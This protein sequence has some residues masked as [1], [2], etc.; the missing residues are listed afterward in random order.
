VNARPDREGRHRRKQDGVAVGRGARGGLR[1]DDGA[2]TGAIFHDHRPLELLLQLLRQDA[3]E[4]VGA[5]AGGKRT[6]ESDRALRIVERLRGRSI[7]RG[8]AADQGE[9]DRPSCASMHPIGH[10]LTRTLTE[11]AVPISPARECAARY[12]G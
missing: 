8:K 5:A 11:Q 6:K 7:E 1:G 12:R 10:Y 9:N 4:D 2:G 3:G